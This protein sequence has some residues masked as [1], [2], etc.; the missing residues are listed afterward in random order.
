L[1]EAA[2]AVGLGVRVED[3]DGKDD[4]EDEK[5]TMKH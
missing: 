1:H 2:A 3:E 4:R 5:K